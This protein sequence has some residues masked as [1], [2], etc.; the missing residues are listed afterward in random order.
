M[1][2]VIAGWI[3]GYATAIIWTLIFCYLLVKATGPNLV[4]R[5]L[6]DG[7]PMGIAAIPISLGLT[8]AWTIVGLIVA[9]VYDLSTLGDAANVLGSPS[10]PV[11]FTA[12]VLAIM[13][14][15]FVLLQWPR[16]WWAW[17]FLS[18]SFLGT[19]GWAFP[20]MAEHGT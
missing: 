20:I 15:P 7:T 18:A 9:I 19:W 6:G 1:S 8:Y 10:G 3:A 4:E 13:P 17:V 12:A 2:A 16:R 11:L 14:L 5:L